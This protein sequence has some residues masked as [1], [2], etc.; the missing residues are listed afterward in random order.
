MKAFPEPA[1]LASLLPL[2][3]PQVPVYVEL[4]GKSPLVRYPVDSRYLC[5]ASEKLRE[6]KR[7]DMSTEHP[8]PTLYTLQQV[9]EM[10]G[11][12]FSTVRRAVDDR[13]L[14]ITRLAP[15]VVRV[16]PEQVQDWISTSSTKTKTSKKAR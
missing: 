6:R 3:W 1:P 8:K 11:V 13:R 10:T 12:S 9:A 7:D 15:R 2:F 16:T 14:Q 4:R 5:S